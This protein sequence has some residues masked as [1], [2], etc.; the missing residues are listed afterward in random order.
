[1]GKEKMDQIISEQALGLYIHIKLHGPGCLEIN[2]V[3]MNQNFISVFI[4]ACY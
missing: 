3:L 1:M 2:A 4:K